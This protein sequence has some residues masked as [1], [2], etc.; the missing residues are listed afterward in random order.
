VLA[1]PDP[2]ADLAHDLSARG[3]FDTAPTPVPSVEV[4][5]LELCERLGGVAADI[6]EE[7]AELG[8]GAREALSVH[9]DT[10]HHEEG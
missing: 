7:L 3:A 1:L 2:T 5:S 8:L 10:H 9:H 4:S 6:T